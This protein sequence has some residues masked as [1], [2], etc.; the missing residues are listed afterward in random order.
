M[1]VIRRRGIGASQVE[2]ARARMHRCATANAR[3][4]GVVLGESAW[5]GTSRA[6]AATRNIASVQDA[7]E[8][9]PRIDN[10]AM[11]A[12][13]YLCTNIS[14]ENVMQELDRRTCSLRCFCACDTAQ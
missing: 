12:I 7:R 10:A 13:C 11:C 6:L 4:G 2:D 3:T 1:E 9:D 14:G 5:K 8:G